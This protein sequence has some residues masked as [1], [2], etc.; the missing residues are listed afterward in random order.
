MEVEDFSFHFSPPASSLSHIHTQNLLYFLVESDKRQ[1]PK[2]FDFH[3]HLKSCCA[4]V[5]SVFIDMKVPKVLQER[6]L[7]GPT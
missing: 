7:C 4:A 5:A 6:M 3:C 2:M 1:S